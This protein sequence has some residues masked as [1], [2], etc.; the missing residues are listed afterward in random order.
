MMKLA[1]DNLADVT[2]RNSGKKTESKSVTSLLI[3]CLIFSLYLWQ[4]AFVG[5]AAELKD[6]L[7]RGYLIV[8]VK[9]NLRPLGFRDAAGNLQGLEIDL[10]KR[11]AQEILGNSEAIKFVP[12][13]N[14]DRLRVVLEGQADL[15]IA[16]VTA[17]AARDRVV[18]FSIPYYMDGIALVTKE[19]NVRSLGDLSQQKIAIL[20]G[21]STIAKLRFILPKAQLV[22]V[23]SYQ[24]G[25]SLL[26]SNGAVAFAADVSVLT[27]WIQ[28]YPQY[29]LL[30]TLL[31]AEPLAVVMPKGIQYDDLRR[32]VN[33]AI[34]RG[35]TQ[36]W[37]PQL[38]TSWGLPWDKVNK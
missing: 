12:V 33:E 26:E 34:D 10:A 13:T 17:T 29:R 11:L 22:G 6:I 18:R 35:K 32:V 38:A 7:Q 25:R 9:D 8:A 3:R 37:L 4:F 20:K 24:E 28:E 23:D 27:G 19:P 14:S 36:G 1:T 16:R 5:N 30:P 21:S 31:S 2:E 15:T